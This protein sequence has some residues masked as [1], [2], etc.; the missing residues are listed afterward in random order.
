MAKPG[1]YAVSQFP[2]GKDFDPSKLAGGR[3][4]RQFDQEGIREGSVSAA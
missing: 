2:S 1:K 3:E 4:L